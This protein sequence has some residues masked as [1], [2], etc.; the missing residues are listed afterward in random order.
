MRNPAITV[1]VG[2]VEI[3][4]HA[5]APPS[6]VYSHF[7]RQITTLCCWYGARVPNNPQDPRVEEEPS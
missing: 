6:G 2:T 3:F 1:A 7:R 4:V 5:F